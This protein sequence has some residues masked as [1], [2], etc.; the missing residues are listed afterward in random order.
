[1]PSRRTTELVPAPQIFPRYFGAN[2]RNRVTAGNPDGDYEIW[3]M[4]K[5]GSDVE[6]LTDNT[7]ND[8]DP[9]WSPNG[10]KIAFSRDDEDILVMRA[11]D[12]ANEENLTDN[13]FFEDDPDFSPNGNRIVYETSRGSDSEIFTV[14]SGGG[15]EKRVTKNQ[16]SDNEPAYSPSGDAIVFGSE[17]DILRMTANGNGR[18]RITHNDKGE[19]SADWGAG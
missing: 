1:L 14:P 7:V 16:V 11:A 12:G 4:R 8:N 5:D 17:D 15:D 3:V 13:G 9:D 19:G 2:A 6:Q 18:H 10:N